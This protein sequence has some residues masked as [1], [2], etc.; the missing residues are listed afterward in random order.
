MRIKSMNCKFSKGGYLRDSC[1]IRFIIELLLFIVLAIILIMFVMHY[2]EIINRLS[3]WAIYG[4]R[5][6]VGG[7]AY[8]LR[9]I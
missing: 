4:K 7:D 1:K 5:F 9:W 8:A 2:R 6:Y 3:F